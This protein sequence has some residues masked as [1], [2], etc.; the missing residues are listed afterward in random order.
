V[1][2]GTMKQ[3]VPAKVAGPSQASR[4]MD[5]SD[6]FVG[7]LLNEALHKVERAALWKWQEA[8]TTLTV[9]AGTQVAT[10]PPADMALPFM[11]RNLGTRR[12]L[13]FH[14]E[15]QRFSFDDD[16]VGRTGRVEQY[17][18]Y[19]GVL[20]FFPTASQDE[21][22][23]LRYYRAWPDMVADTDVP[24]FP[25]TWHDLLTSYAAAKLALRLQPVAGKYLPESA[26]RPFQEEWEQGLYAMTQS[27]LAL[28]TWDKVEN[29]DVTESMWAGEGV[30]W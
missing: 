8:Q 21:T 19:N 13:T 11:A 3:I 26:A 28:T 27:P 20:R 15:R 10:V 1:N 5:V 30:D 6:V 22:I 7:A 29:H 24:P 4:L 25:E 17:G 12:D 2:F 16:P 9:L 14:D 23:A 18:I